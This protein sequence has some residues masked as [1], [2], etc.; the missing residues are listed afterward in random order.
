MSRIKARA[1]SKLRG[2]QREAVRKRKKLNV[3]DEIH[4]DDTCS[5]TVGE[6]IGEITFVVGEAPSDIVVHSSGRS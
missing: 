5:S 2:L 3:L 4:T 1:G 6:C